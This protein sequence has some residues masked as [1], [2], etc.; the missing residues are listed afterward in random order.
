MTR[1]ALLNWLPLGA[2]LLLSFTRLPPV[3]SGV[4]G[5][6][7]ASPIG[8]A[9][10]HA[11]VGG[12]QLVAADGRPLDLN[13]FRGKAVFVNLWATWCAPCRAELPGIEALAAR[14]DTSKI[15]FVLISLDQNPAKALKFG[16]RHGL[17]LPVYF[18]AAPLPP[19][20]NSPIIPTTIILSPDGRVAARYE[21]QVDYD[22]PE[23][24]Q[25]LARLAAQR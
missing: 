3:G 18:P 2:L 13:K 17:R 5:A 14:V 25:A 21:G 6:A 11:A 23:F 24:R 20:F 22:T 16:Q 7:S 1:Q 12:L 8:P 19:P 9:G 15:A 10:S 4:V